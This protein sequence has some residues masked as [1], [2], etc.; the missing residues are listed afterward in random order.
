[1]SRVPSEILVLFS[2]LRLIALRQVYFPARLR[3][4]ERD[5]KN[6]PQQGAPAPSVHREIHR[7]GFFAENKSEKIPIGT[8]KS[9]IDGM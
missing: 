4:K 1:M 6:H 9:N 5:S 2:R 8:G 3:L 7:H